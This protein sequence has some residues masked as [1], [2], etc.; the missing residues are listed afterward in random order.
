MKYLSQLIKCSAKLTLLFFMSASQAEAAQ[1]V[2][3]GSVPSGWIKIND[4]W[5]S[6][7]CGSPP[8]T[9]RNV[10]TIAQYSNKPV[11]FT[12]EVCNGTVPDGWGIVGTNTSLSTCMSPS[13]TKNIMT[14]RRFN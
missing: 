9:V 5:G 4:S 1:Q 14:I 10:W 3:A 8:S 7:S 2:C 12:M 13:Q 6:S 11:G